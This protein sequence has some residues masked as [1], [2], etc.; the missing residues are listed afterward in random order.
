MIN[1][2]TDECRALL[3]DPD[4]VARERAQRAR[5][6]QLLDHIV[7]VLQV[8]ADDT[9]VDAWPDCAELLRAFVPTREFNFLVT[10]LTRMESERL[11]NRLAIALGL[12]GL[13]D[14]R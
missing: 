9:A 13:R 12:P 1:L 11:G 2:S 3:A 14:R 4:P 8:L 7:V 6:T 5:R 10:A